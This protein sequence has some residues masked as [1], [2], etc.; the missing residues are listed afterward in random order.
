MTRIAAEMMAFRL[1][2]LLGLA[3]FLILGLHDQYKRVASQS[4][5]TRVAVRRTRADFEMVG[6]AGFEP[7]TTRTPSE[8]ATSLRH[9]PTRRTLYIRCRQDH[10]RVRAGMTVREDQTFFLGATRGRHCTNARRSA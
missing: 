8:C 6:V 1:S 7:A 2:S 3:M 10:T 5:K 9:T 4:T